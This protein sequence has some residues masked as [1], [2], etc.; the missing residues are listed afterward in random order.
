VIRDAH[1]KALARNTATASDDV[2]MAID[3]G[4]RV[5][6]VEGAYT[7]IKITTPY[8]YEAAQMIATK[9]LYT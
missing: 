5:K 6:I 9:G 7:N 4:Y 8:D 3:A 2:Q 1:E